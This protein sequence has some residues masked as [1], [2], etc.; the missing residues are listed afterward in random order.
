MIKNIMYKKRRKKLFDLMKNNSMVLIEA[1]QEKY[2]N[3]D[4][5]LDIDN[6]VIFIT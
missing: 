2:R 6:A 1:A 4:S 3:N 5:T